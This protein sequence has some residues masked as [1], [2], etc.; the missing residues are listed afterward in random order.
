MDL[1]EAAKKA[2]SSREHLAAARRL[3]LEEG[4]DPNM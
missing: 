2:G 3:L 1:I 4:S